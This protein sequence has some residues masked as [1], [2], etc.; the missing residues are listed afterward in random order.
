[1]S[2]K[3]QEILTEK[4]IKRQPINHHKVTIIKR[5]QIKFQIQE[6]NLFFHLIEGIRLK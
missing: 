4:D 6:I 3:G 2:K 1:M 5:M